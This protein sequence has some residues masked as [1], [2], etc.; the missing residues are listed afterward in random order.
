LRSS[1]DSTSS[2]GAE[3][4]SDQEVH[5]TSTDADGPRERG[6]P[7]NKGTQTDIQ[8]SISP[9][10][11]VAG[12]SVLPYQHS[13]IV[14]SS[15]ETSR[16]NSRPRSSPYIPSDTY[17]GPAD[18]SQG[19]LPTIS[20]SG[21]KGSRASHLSK[22]RR[23]QHSHQNPQPELSTPTV[24]FVVPLAGVLTAFAARITD[25]GA[26]NSIYSRDDS[27]ERAPILI[28]APRNI[29]AATRVRESK[30]V[31]DVKKTVL[32]FVCL[33]FLCITVLICVFFGSESAVP[34]DASFRK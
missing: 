17:S 25:M 29:E 34:F 10:I 2:S 21:R 1:S 20:S 23:R 4:E 7:F 14:A 16:Q 22:S 19:K 3:A 9:V 28:D 32:L 12:V 30:P 15:P 24:Q 8:E 11:A 6:L 31:W 13:S 5:A 33:I 26:Q 27:P 18:Q